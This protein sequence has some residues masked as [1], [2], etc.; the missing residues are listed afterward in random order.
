MTNKRTIYIDTLDSASM[1][2]EFL[3]NTSLEYDYNSKYQ[4]ITSRKVSPKAKRIM[5]TA[6][7]IGLLGFISTF[8]FQYCACI[9]YYPLNIGNRPMFS[10]ITVLPYAFE[11]AVLLAGLGGF[12]AFLILSNYSDK[13]IDENTNCNVKFI[14][15]KKDF[16]EC[17]TFCK[18]N[19]INFEVDETED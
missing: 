4:L 17:R 10:I 16:E 1:L 2:A 6:L 8:L 11:I 7:I 12:I 18:N 3:E 5:T 14:I 19:N 9:Y 13:Q 15:N